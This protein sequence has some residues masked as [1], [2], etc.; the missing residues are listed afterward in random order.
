MAECT[1]KDK[2]G[3]HQ[4]TDFDFEAEDFHYIFSK[5]E[6]AIKAKRQDVLLSLASV[7]VLYS[8][9]LAIFVRIHQMMYKNN[10]RFVISDISQE[11]RN[12][13]QI[14]QLDSIFSIYETFDDFKNSLKISE[15]EQK[16]DLNF[17]WQIIKNNE[18]DVKIICKGNMFAGKQLDELQKSILD[19]F[20]IT[21]DFS[22][23]Q[24][25]DSASIEFLGRIADKHTVSVIGA[26]KELVEQFRQ[27]LIYGKMKQLT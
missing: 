20:S 17:E 6:N 21:F 5:I 10:L 27:K 26:N 23:L 24:S 16:S 14:T 2:G 12:L 18:D 9:H 4:I 25:M 11:I 1:I 8:S 22:A 13:L 19:F 15:E 7:G 3:F